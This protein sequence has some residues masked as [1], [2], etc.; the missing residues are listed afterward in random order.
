MAFSTINKSSDYFT[1]KTLTA[2]Q[3]SSMVVTGVGFQPDMVWLKS[4]D[5]NF[6]WKQYDAVRGIQ[7]SLRSDTN[8]AEATISDGL[9]SYDSDGFTHGTDSDINYGNTNP[10]SWNWKAGTTGSGNTGG[11]GTAKTYSY[12]V[13][14]TA[15]FS[16]VKY[17]GN[18]NAGQ[19]V[20]HHLGVKPGLIIVKN[21]S[22]AR[23]WVV[24]SSGGT[25]TKNT[26]L[27]STEPE[28]DSGGGGWSQGIIGVPT[29]S[30]ITFTA[31]ATNNNHICINDENYIAYCFAEIT[32]YSK[33]GSYTGNGNADGAFIYTGFRP[34][35]VT[36]KRTSGT[37]SWRMWDNKREGYNGNNTFVY[38]NLSNAEETGDNGTYADLLS[39]GFKWR[40]TS[41]DMNGS[42]SS[43]I[44]MA[45]GQPIISN[46]GVCATAR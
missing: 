14:T 18:G 24:W 46:S 8:S 23:H 20:P 4:R 33:F 29:S 7:K 16:I 32:G 31:G 26:S 43:Y 6:A 44:Y 27:N 10:M 37:G 19:T 2:N 40:G 36:A 11:L 45:F 35:W 38:A 42:G 12:S 34:A 13:N 17:V 22:A 5:Q 9:L 30:N 21:L 39:N 15:G 41:G 28:H 1:P 25:S 3:G